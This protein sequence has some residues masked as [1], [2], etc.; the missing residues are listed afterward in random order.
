H[1]RSVVDG[2]LRLRRIGGSPPR[3]RAAPGPAGG[4]PPSRQRDRALTSARTRA[5]ERRSG[6]GAFIPSAATGGLPPWEAGEA[7]RTPP[8]P[9]NSSRYD[10]VAR[11]H[12]SAG[13]EPVTDVAQR[14]RTLSAMTLE[15][16]TT[17]AEGSA[18]H[19]PCSSTGASSTSF[20][21]NG[22]AILTGMAAT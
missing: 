1:G 3:A 10:H 8:Q 2:G 11:W 18:A 22:S 15:G 9:S 14:S 5:S 7:A 16:A 21:G 13:P 6:P 12:F 4:P 19:A 20:P 17:R